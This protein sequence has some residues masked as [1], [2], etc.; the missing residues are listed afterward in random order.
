MKEIGRIMAETI[1]YIEREEIA[2]PD[3]QPISRYTEMV[4][5][6]R[7]SLY[8]EIKRYATRTREKAFLYLILPLPVFADS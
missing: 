7:V 2:G 4:E 3:Y 8:S 5:P 1:I 6:G